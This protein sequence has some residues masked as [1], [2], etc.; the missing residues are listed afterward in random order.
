MSKAKKTVV[1]GT[2][3]QTTNPANNLPE[4]P[5]V[6]A[7]TTKSDRKSG[8]NIV[9]QTENEEAI[10]ASDEI[11]LIDKISA[12][13]P[14]PTFD[15]EAAFAGAVS[16]FGTPASF[17]DFNKINAE[18]SDLEKVWKKDH[19]DEIKAVE[20][21][22]FE[23][24]WET[25]TAA[26][27]DAEIS[28][29]IDNFTTGLIFSSEK[30][31]TIIYH[32]GQSDTSDKFLCGAVEKD[33]LRGET[34]GNNYYYHYDDNNGLQAYL[35]AIRTL[36]YYTDCQNKTAKEVKNVNKGIINNYS[37]MLID[38]VVSF[39]SRYGLTLEQ[40]YNR[41]TFDREGLDK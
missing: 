38:R 14:V 5:V 18:I 32:T 21:I 34:V 24:F 8:A 25:V 37:G 40:A 17:D 31:A 1:P 12:L 39:A 28:K 33:N 29:G 3:G 36:K 4:V 11:S 10:I 7:T 20:N 15:R 23:K 27:L 13:F 6:D 41:V 9:E 26:G 2:D 16:K 30:N 22:S 35:R 19:S